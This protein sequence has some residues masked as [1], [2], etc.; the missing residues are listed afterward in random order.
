MAE[1]WEQALGMAPQQPDPLQSGDIMRVLGANSQMM[2]PDEAMEFNPPQVPLPDDF[3]S[4]LALAGVQFGHPGR[5]TS[6]TP[7]GGLAALLGLASAFGNYKVG[8]ARRKISDIDQKNVDL[9]EAA[10][11]L[12]RRRNEARLQAR[13]LEATKTNLQSNEALRRD[14]AQVYSEPLVPVQ[15]AEGIRYMR[16]SEAAGMAA[17]PRA[18]QARR[19]IQVIGPDGFPVWTTQEDAIGERSIVTG[20]AVTGQERQA[21]SFYNRAKQAVETLET[22]D[23]SGRTLEDRVSNVNIVKQGQSVYAP[24]VL[25]TPEQRAYV[26]AQRAFT[27]ARLRKE[28]GAA[29][30]NS[31]YANDR[32]T[33]FRQPGD[34][35]ATIEQ[36]RLARQQVLDGMRFASG[37]AYDEYYG[38]PQPPPTGARPT[39]KPAPGSTKKPIRTKFVNGKLVEVE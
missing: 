8:R 3:A 27:E 38:S 5:I 39:T 7:G 18:T 24:N 16:R 21:L 17:P 15:T 36:K 23:D 30:P 26:Q 33:Y 37:R 11:R 28:S 29:I 2:Y 35:P 4:R 32:V 9:R 31:E 22:V 12:A 34:D 25:K 13:Q 19:L 1:W 6:Q 14:L 10:Q 20:K